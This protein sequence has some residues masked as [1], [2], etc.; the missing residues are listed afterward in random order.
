LFFSPGETEKSFSVVINRDSRVEMPFESFT[1][2]LSSPTGG[3]ALG[4]TATATVQIDD[5]SGG[6][7]PDSM[8]SMTRA[9]LSAS[10]I[11]IS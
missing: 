1:V 3:A 8:S 4:E 10:S 7:P 9:L 5:I 11:T 6:L 2:K